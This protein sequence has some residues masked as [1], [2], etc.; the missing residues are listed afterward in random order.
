MKVELQCIVPVKSR[1][2][3]FLIWTVWG[4]ISLGRRFI[5]PL[6][7]LVKVPV[8]SIGVGLYQHDVPAKKLEEQLGNVVED[9]VN[10]I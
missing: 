5:D 2:K 4:T 3:N 6:S 8:G 1:K 9:V 10:E 7:E